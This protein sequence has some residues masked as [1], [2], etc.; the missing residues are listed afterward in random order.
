M[1]QI[2]YLELLLAGPHIDISPPD[3]Q[4]LTWVQLTNCRTLSALLQKHVKSFNHYG[5]EVV[6]HINF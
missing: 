4:S 2:L 1:T 6:N 5:F 3:D